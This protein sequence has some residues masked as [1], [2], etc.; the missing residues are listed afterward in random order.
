MVFICNLLKL[1]DAHVY[2]YRGGLQLYLILES[3]YMGIHFHAEN[4]RSFEAI[5]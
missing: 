5:R 1:D 4:Q 2:S 3:V